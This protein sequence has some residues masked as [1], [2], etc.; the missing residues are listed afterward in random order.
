MPYW[1]VEVEVKHMREAER[2]NKLQKNLRAILIIRIISS[3]FAFLFIA[4]IIY[5]HYSA[6]TNT[7]N[8]LLYISIAILFFEG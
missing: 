7:F 6:I 1:W 2:Q 8:N 4:C 5:A 3:M